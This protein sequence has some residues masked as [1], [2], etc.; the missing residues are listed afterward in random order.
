M[1][2]T[3]TPEM[4]LLLELATSNLA[5]RW[6]REMAIITPQQLSER[7]AEERLD[8]MGLRDEVEAQDGS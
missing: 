3:L 6:A 4:I 1:P 7:V 5:R 2:F 8:Q